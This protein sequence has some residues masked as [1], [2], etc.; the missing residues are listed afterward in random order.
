MRD[1]ASLY[2]LAEMG[3]DVYL[4]RRCGESMPGVAPVLAP[5]PASVTAMP[6][7]DHSAR[8]M[9]RVQ[10]HAASVFLLADAPTPG[11]KKLLADV[12]CA[13][14]FARVPCA[15]TRG[16]DEVAMATATALILFGETH[17]RAAGARL[18]A[19]QQREIGWVVSADAA[20]LVGDAAAKRALWSELKR[21][22]R[23]LD[24]RRGR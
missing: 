19:Q 10:A 8:E 4:P 12:V 5:R 7:A 14:V 11:A 16:D 22:A 23:G 9:S 21:M 2:R 13:L 1:E 17:A 24:A 15:Q 6:A 20:A 18:P 3:V